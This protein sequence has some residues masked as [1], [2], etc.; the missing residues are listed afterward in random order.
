VKRTGR[1][2]LD[3]DEPSASVHLRLPPRTYDAAYQRA[4]RDQVSVPEVLR[5]ALDRELRDDDQEK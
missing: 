3:A 1:P 4:Q 2:P 5:R